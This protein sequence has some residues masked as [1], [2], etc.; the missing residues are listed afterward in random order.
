VDAISPIFLNFFTAPN[1]FHVSFL[2]AGGLFYATL[3]GEK[4]VLG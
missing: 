1:L 2:S 4:R 3:S